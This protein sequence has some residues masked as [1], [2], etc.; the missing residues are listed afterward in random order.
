MSANRTV[1]SATTAMLITALALGSAGAHQDFV[2]QVAYQLDAIRAEIASDFEAASDIGIGELE[3]G[4]E[5][6]F[7]VEVFEGVEYVIIGVCDADCGDLDLAAWSDDDEEIASDI[8]Y[9][10]YPVLRFEAPY[11][12]EVYVGVLMA[13]C[14]AD[15]CVWGVQGYAR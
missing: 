6:A 7:T 12:G 14:G 4:D 5:G 2:D 8:E 15:T 1:A 3:P 9:D 11:D 10:D 13:D